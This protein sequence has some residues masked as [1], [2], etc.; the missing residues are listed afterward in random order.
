M[1]RWCGKNATALATTIKRRQQLTV[2]LIFY[3]VFMCCLA[4]AW[5]GL[6]TSA[7]LRYIFTS[8]LTV[9]PFSVVTV[10]DA[11][12]SRKDV[13][14]SEF[15]VRPMF[16]TSFWCE[17]LAT[18]ERQWKFIDIEEKHVHHVTVSKVIESDLYRRVESFHVHRD[19]RVLL[20]YKRVSLRTTKTYRR[21]VSPVEQGFDP[22]SGNSLFDKFFSNLASRPS[23]AWISI[24]F[25]VVLVPVH[26]ID[27]LQ[28]E[29]SS[30]FQLKTHRLSLCGVSSLY[31]VF[32]INRSLSRLYILYS[33]RL[34]CSLRRWLEG[35]VLFL[36]FFWGNLLFHGHIL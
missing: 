7:V 35:H 19:V 10:S 36:F 31:N 26:V 11:E 22:R 4:W 3:V 9:D 2:I 21:T 32:L 28:S 33:S 34:R 14:N 16:R 30:K 27:K 24:F 5:W 18:N 20:A 8:F 25:S 17:D 12:I 1:I 6:W 15:H 23:S 13:S 29:I